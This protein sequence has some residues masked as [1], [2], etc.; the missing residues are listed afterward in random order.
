MKSTYRVSGRPV[1]SRARH[2]AEAGEGDRQADQAQ[3]RDETLVRHQDRRDEQADPPLPGDNHG[4]AE[5]A[6]QEA[7][8]CEPQ[9]DVAAPFEKG[10]HGVEREACRQTQ[11]GRG[12]ANQS[13]EQQ[14]SPRR[15]QIGHGLEREARSGHDTG[16]NRPSPGGHQR[17]EQPV[18]QRLDLAV[19]RVAL[20]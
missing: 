5:H 17:S 11:H 14:V 1:P 13:S 15:T 10:I 3:H 9:Q 12:G 2:S 16:G 6:K 20:I 4:E 18:S 8:N 19:A 7:A